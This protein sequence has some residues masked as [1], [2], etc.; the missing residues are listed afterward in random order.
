TPYTVSV[1]N[2]INSRCPRASTAAVM[3]ALRCSDCCSSNCC[4]T[5]VIVPG[6]GWFLRLIAPSPSGSLIRIGQYAYDPAV[7]SPLA[8]QHVAAEL[9]P[10]GGHVS[11]RVP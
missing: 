6:L 3:A 1:G 10:D 7:W 4:V 5:L 9:K 2:T 8:T 11:R